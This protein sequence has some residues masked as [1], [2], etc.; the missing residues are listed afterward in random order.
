MRH[1]SIIR[2]D[3]HLTSLLAAGAAVTLLA[4]CGGEPPPGSVEAEEVIDDV[5]YYY[6]CGNETLE[7]GDGRTYYPLFPEEQDDFDDSPYEAPAATALGGG[8]IAV[9]PPGPGD[10]TGA[11]TV[12]EDGMAHWRSD[13]G[14]VAWLTEEP[15]EYEWIC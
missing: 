10:D 9:A 6:A 2:R 1:F 5:E 13:S 8:L 4:A 3:R 7:L 15:Q 12:Y 11:L 14:T